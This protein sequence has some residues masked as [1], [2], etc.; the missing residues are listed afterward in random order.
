MSLTKMELL[1]EVNNEQNRQGVNNNILAVFAFSWNVT[2][3]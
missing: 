1:K 3:F 2:L